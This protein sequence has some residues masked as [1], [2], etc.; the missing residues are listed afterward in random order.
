M[1]EFTTKQIAELLG[2]SKPTV[3]KEIKRLAVEPERRENNNR[4]FYSYADT[5]SVIKAIR[6][7][8]DFSL[9]SQ[10]GEKP[11]NETAKPQNEP[12]NTAKP[13][14]LVQN[15]EGQTAKPQNEELEFLKRALSVIEAQ[16]AEKDK[17]L[18][19]KDE[20]IKDLSN[21]LAEAM[22]LT[23]GQQYITAAD[24]TTELLEVD[25]KRGQQDEPPIVIHE[26]ATIK[27]ESK[28]AFET[29]KS[30]SSTEEEPQL[31]SIKSFWKRLFGR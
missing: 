5:V 30:N 21:R 10:F 3:Q 29:N 22:Q 28:P 27:K 25:S 18:E 2:V 20:Q 14:N 23:R 6:P 13:Q 19:K 16:L 4:A 11:Q 26:E 24:K 31:L 12:Q 8:Y 17:Q 1:M 9:L 7:N 15:S